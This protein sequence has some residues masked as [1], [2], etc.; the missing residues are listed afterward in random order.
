[1][2]LLEKFKQHIHYDEGIDEAM[3]SVYLSNAER[4]VKNGTGKVSE[5]LVLL[6]AGIMWEYRA[7]EKELEDAL[8]AITP[9]FV[10]EVYA[11]ETETNN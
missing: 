9:F 8:N 6:V 4:Y 1:M 2:N 11:D 3:L 10:Q 5:Y 7:S